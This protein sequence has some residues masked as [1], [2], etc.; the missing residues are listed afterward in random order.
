[1]TLDTD[2][3]LRQV[4]PL[5]LRSAGNTY[6]EQHMELVVQQIEQG[7]EIHEALAATRAFPPEFLETVAVGESSGSLAEAMGRLSEQYEQRA[8]AA[9]ETLSMLASLAVWAIVAALI[10]WMIFRLAFFYLNIL[11]GA[12]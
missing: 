9:I 12:L 11:Y 2:M 1:M 7:R 8:D 6:Y 4:L 5:V 10:I 3:D